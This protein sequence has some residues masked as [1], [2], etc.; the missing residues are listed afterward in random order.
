MA[1]NNGTYPCRY[2]ACIAPFTCCV[3]NIVWSVKCWVSCCKAYHPCG[4]LGTQPSVVCYTCRVYS[5][6]A[7]YP[8]T[9]MSKALQK[10]SSAFLSFNFNPPLSIASHCHLPL[11]LK[12]P[13]SEE[14]LFMPRVSLRT[15]SAF[16]SALTSAALFLATSLGSNCTCVRSS[17]AAPENLQ[18]MTSRDCSGCVIILNMSGTVLRS[19]EGS[20][21]PWAFCSLD[22]HPHNSCQG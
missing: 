14:M 7:N 3:H 8:A 19:V 22:H 6:T 9:A 13:N 15:C 2:T 18:C 12:L 20:D 5:A 16:A 1:T 4:S 11:H 10:F 17:K 21:T